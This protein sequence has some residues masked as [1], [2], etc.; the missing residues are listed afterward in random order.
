MQEVSHLKP[1]PSGSKPLIPWTVAAST[2][3][4][5]ALMLGIGNQHLGRFQI[6]YSLDAQSEMSVELVEAPIVQDIIVEPEVRNQIGST[7]AG[8][9]RDTPRQKP[10]KVLL[11][12]AEAEDENSVKTKQ[13]WIQSEPIKGSRAY[14]MFS[15][16]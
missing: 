3:V 5:I 15:T 14:G 8:G 2:A 9:K 6:P 7:N 11:S 1:T 16:P 13:Q 12:A 4:L 10:D